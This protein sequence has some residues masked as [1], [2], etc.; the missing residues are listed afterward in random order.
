MK[1]E[2]KRALVTGAGSGM[3]RAIA[4][5]LASDGAR[6][7][8][9]DINS[10]S[11]KAVCT[12]IEKAGG[13]AMAVPA[14]V[15]S[16][17]QVKQQ[18]ER[19]FEAWKGLDIIVTNAGY[20]QYCPLEDVTDEQWDRMQAV[21]VKGAFN[22]IKCVLPFMK[23][24]KYGRIV[25]MS[26]VSGMTGTPNHAHYSAAKGALIGLTRGLAK[27][28]ASFGIHVNAIAPG[29]IETPFLKATPSSLI[30]AYL[31]RTPLKRAGRPEDIAPV[32]R[33]L[34]SDDANFIVGQVISPNGGFLIS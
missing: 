9:N 17:E 21:H 28:V 33:F 12:E 30:Q 13:R 24:Q 5:E 18:I 34:V 23:S 6:V 15:A 26:S 4:L 22:C 11:A 31:D 25:I 7:A 32:C 20:G 29:L 27:E 14:D 2:G 10:D 19:I 8:V 3:G 16:F 1:L